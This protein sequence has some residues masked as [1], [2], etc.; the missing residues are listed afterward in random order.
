M[1]RHQLKS[2]SEDELAMALFVVN[3]LSPAISG[4]ELPPEGLTWFRKGALE[5]KLM[6]SFNHLT[7]EAHPTFSSLLTKLGVAH[8]IRYEQP[9]TGSVDSSPISQPTGSL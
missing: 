4:S 6:G 1:T 7:K 5:Q 9:P 3:H 2:L 8:E